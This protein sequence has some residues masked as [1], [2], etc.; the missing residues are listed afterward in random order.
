MDRHGKSF[1]MVF[2]CDLEEVSNTVN[3]CIAQ[4]EEC[5]GEDRMDLG[6]IT[7]I[8]WVVTELVTNAI[9][10]S[11]VGECLMI[12][13]SNEKELLIEKQEDG[14]P[15]TLTEYAIG[16]S[17]SWPI[18]HDLFPQVF[19]LYHNGSESLWVSAPDPS[20]A[21]F[22]VKELGIPHIP[23]LLADTS[24]H[25]GLLILTKA[26]DAFEYRREAG[27]NHFRSTFNLKND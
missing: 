16:K 3:L 11:G 10:H 18:Q 8:K 17:V 25:F 1:D 19:Q 5:V 27:I 6:I 26:S 4:I 9:K 15:L 20:R 2:K 21:V 23:E 13:Q 24:E 22:H 12:I 14:H 7:R